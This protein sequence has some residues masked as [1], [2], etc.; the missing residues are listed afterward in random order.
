[1]GTKEEADHVWDLAVTVTAED[2]AT[3]VC[4][5]ETM[6]LPDIEKLGL[7]D[8][9]TGPAM[10]G[11]IVPSIMTVSWPFNAGFGADVEVGAVLLEV[12]PTSVSVDPV[13]RS[14]GSEDTV[15]APD[16]GMTIYKTPSNITV[17]PC[18]S[19]YDCMSAVGIVVI[20]SSIGMRVVLC[21]SFSV[22]IAGFDGSFVMVLVVTDETLV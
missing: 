9:V 19:V 4:P 15:V 2:T 21:V 17:L 5:L 22:F 10:I 18:A 7:K 14:S 11:S 20:S 16:P 12:A 8:T 1:M 3:Q 13:G 6:V